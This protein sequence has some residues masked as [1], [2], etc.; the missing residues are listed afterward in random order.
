MDANGM[1]NAAGGRVR[2]ADKDGAGVTGTGGVRATAPAKAAPAAGEVRPRLTEDLLER[3]LSSHS[4]DAY[5][6]ETA[7][8]DRVLVEYLNELLRDHGLKRAEV[9][10]ASG[11]NATVVYDIFAGKS[12]PGRDH[13]IML[14]F[15]LGC[16][17]KECQRLLRLAGVAELWCKAR[18]DAII[19]WCL[20]QGLTRAQADDELYRLGEKTLLST[21]RFH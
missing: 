12:K 14:A 7:P 5:L 13:A 6:D 16:T 17:L 21:G 2:A 1:A 8:A 4:I 3:L 18:R 19:I 10:R 9:I 15:G 11:I 20:E